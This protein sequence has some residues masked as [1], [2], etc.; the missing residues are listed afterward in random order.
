MEKGEV[1][2][3]LVAEPTKLWHTSGEADWVAAR[4]SG[5]AVA[6]N[7]RA[8]RIQTG[9]GVVGMMLLWRRPAELGMR[10]G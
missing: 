9:L 6:M 1:F 3:G 8:W 7:L 10:L 5:L 4:C 2:G